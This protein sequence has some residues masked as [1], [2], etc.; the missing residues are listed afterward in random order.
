MR[1]TVATF[2]IHHG[3]GADGI[4]DLTRTAAAIDATGAE[5]IALQELDDGLA[6]TGRVDQPRALAELTGLSV[7]FLPT[8]RRGGGRYG[9]ALAA[10]G[11][12]DVEYRELPRLGDEDRRGVA[13]TR[14][15]DIT[16]VGTHISRPRAPRRKQIPALAEFV[17]SLERPV[18][19]MGDLNSTR[20]SLRPL[21]AAG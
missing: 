15:R 21:K 20:W 12:L 16:V 2:N 6:R 1:F 19:L 4:L 13:V 7:H 9:I 11:P 10:T 5:L 18:L 17:G 3:R 14:W 8:L